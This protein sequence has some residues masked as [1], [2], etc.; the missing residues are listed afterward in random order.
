MSVDEGQDVVL[1][2][3]SNYSLSDVLRGE[4]KLRNIEPIREN[5]IKLGNDLRYKEGSGFLAKKVAEKITDK[6]VVDSIR[7]SAE[8]EEL[9]KLKAI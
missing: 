5:L 7:S 6:S 8:I 2:I 3:E 1:I 9:R 4:A